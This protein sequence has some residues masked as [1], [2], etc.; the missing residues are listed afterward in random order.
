GIT[1][2]MVEAEEEA[3]QAIQRLD[4]LSR[5]E[6]RAQFE[7]RFSAERMAQDYVAHYGALISIKPEHR[8]GS[9]MQE[10]GTQLICPA[11]DNLGGVAMQSLRSLAGRTTAPGSRT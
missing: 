3:V 1:G 7:R 9:A 11:P 5:Y 8:A 4:K 6:V 2:F 10:A